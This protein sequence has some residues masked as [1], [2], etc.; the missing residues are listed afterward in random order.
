MIFVVEFGSEKVSNTDLSNVI[1]NEL[2]IEQSAA[3]GCW[4]PRA[5]WN[6]NSIIQLHS[7]YRIGSDSADTFSRVLSWWKISCVVISMQLLIHFSQGYLAEQEN[8]CVVF[9]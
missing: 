2:V 3:S 5:N 8:P 9:P 7:I 6:S 1:D 4:L